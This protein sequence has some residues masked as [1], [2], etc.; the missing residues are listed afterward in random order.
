MKKTLLSIAAA[1]MVFASS[2]AALAQGNGNQGN[3]NTVIP[4]DE[5]VYGNTYGE[6]TAGHFN[7]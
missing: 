4:V 5:V 6:W 1:I 2:S 7:G 3:G